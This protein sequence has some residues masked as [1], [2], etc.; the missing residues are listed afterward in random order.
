[1]YLS[2]CCCCSLLTGAVMTGIV[3][4]TAYI[5]GFSLEVWWIVVAEEQLPIPAFLLCLIYL[6]L[7]ILSLTM[8]VGLRSQR[9]YLILSWISMVLILLFP[10]A[11]MVLFMALYHWNTNTNGILELILWTL[12][13]IF[14]IGGMV[15]THSLYA[16]W[17]NEKSIIK[18]LHELSLNKSCYNSTPQSIVVHSTS[19]KLGYPNPAYTSSIPNNINSTMS[20]TKYTTKPLKRSVSS[21]SQFV[22]A[23]RI[24][25]NNH[26]HNHSHSPQQYAFQQT[27]HL[28]N[29]ATLST[30]SYYK[31]HS[32]SGGV[33]RNSSSMDLPSFGLHPDDPVFVGGGK[34]NPHFSMSQNIQWHRPR[35]LV[36]IGQCCGRGQSLDGDLWDPMSFRCNCA[37]HNRFSLR[38]SDKKSHSTG[39]L[40]QLSSKQRDYSFRPHRSNFYHYSDDDS[41]H[42]NEIGNSFDKERGYRSRTSSDHVDEYRD[43][44]L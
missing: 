33:S 32:S 2:K 1:M 16:S 41:D 35:S 20:V 13:V 34:N 38:C 24:H 29:Q 30:P 39:S 22:S 23:S 19:N 10:E 36:D 31:Q 8:L 6:I 9:T 42:G 28:Y 4:L 40:N 37:G 25:G 21:A 18:S 26:Y 3:S 43:V 15:C 12:R 14:N 17:K 27:Q 11:G 7:S 44:A 5:M